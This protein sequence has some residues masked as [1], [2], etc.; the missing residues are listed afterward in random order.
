MEVGMRKKQNILQVRKQG[1]YCTTLISGQCKNTNMPRTRVNSKEIQCR[2]DTTFDIR[3]FCFIGFVSCSWWRPTRPRCPGGSMLC[4]IRL[5]LSSPLSYNVTMSPYDSTYVK[6]LYN[7][8]ICPT[9]PWLAST[10][11][12]APKHVRAAQPSHSKVSL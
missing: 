11:F 4:A 1:T 2:I 6:L 7:F 10:P 9:H 5:K 8:V 3:T 12:R